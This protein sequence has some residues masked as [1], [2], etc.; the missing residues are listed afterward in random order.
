[1]END[2]AKNSCGPEPAPALGSGLTAPEEGVVIN[3]EGIRDP[4]VDNSMTD[5]MATSL[6]DEQDCGF[7]GKTKDYLFYFSMQKTKGARD[8]D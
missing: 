7:F 8:A 1:V 4:P 5:G 3:I 2:H 6:V